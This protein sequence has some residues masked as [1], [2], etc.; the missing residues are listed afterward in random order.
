[1]K[2]RFPSKLN[3]RLI[4]AFAVL[5]A[6]FIIHSC[7]KDNSGNRQ[8]DVLNTGLVN[9]AKQWY[10]TTYSEASN[11]GKLATQSIGGAPNAWNQ[12][13]VPYWDKANTYTIDSLPYIELPALKRGDMAMTTQNVNPASF[14]FA[15]S[16]SFS[17]QLADRFA[18]A[19]HI[20]PTS[21]APEHFA[22][23]LSFEGLP[24]QRRL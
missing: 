14:N 11:T 3:P 9:M 23:P 22:L 7:K 2:L 4:I 12:M 17:I 10:T 21:S 5:L 16:R 24:D 6:A 20:A 1:M 19:Q 8:P 13:F 18:A 15:Q